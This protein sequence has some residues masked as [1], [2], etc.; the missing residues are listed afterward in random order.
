GGGQEERELA[1]MVDGLRRTGM[2]VVPNV[3]PA[4]YSRDVQIRASFPALH[5]NVTQLP[6]RTV[7]QK[8]YSYGIPTAANHWSGFNRGAWSDP[9][10]DQLTVAFDTT[11]DRDERNQQMIQMMQIVAEVVPV[12]PLFYNLDAVAVTSAVAGPTTS[13]PDTTREWNVQ[14]WRWTG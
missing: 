4:V 3:V 14:D 13:A 6:E 8:L 2:E 7:F 5:A 10:F 1:I 9:A 12:I 11:L